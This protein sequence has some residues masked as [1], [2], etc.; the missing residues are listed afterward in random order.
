MNFDL[1]AEQR[2]CRQ[3]ARNLGKKEIAPKVADYN[4]S[5]RFPLEIYKKMGQ[6]GILGGTIPRRWDGAGIDHVSLALV[7]EELGYFCLE[8]AAVVGM[9][10]TMF[11]DI[12]LQHGTERQRERYLRPLCKG[13]TLASCAVTEPQGGSDVAAVA[14]TAVPRGNGYLINGSKSWISYAASADWLLTLARIGD[15]TEGGGFGA[16]IVEKGF[17]GLSISRI[18]NKLGD[19]L[20]DASD[21]FFEDCPVP[22]ENMVGGEGDGLRVILAALEG[23]RLCFAARCCGGI[24]ACL[25]ESTNYA[26][27]RIVFGRPIGQNQLVQ[28]KIADMAVNL[29]CARWLTYHLA[30]LKDT[31]LARATQESSMAKLFAT[32]AFMKA[33]TSAVQIYGAYGC[34]DDSKV[35][36]LFRDAKVHQI[37]EGTSEIH[38]MLIAEYA[39]G[40]RSK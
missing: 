30:W 16:F 33:A 38:I 22:R 21:V 9:I 40:Y 32:D 7:C 29:E 1:T 6:E 2:E 31:G 37:M 28:A 20:G 26:R 15:S 12:L 18:H 36:R 4:R 10:S 5:E 25:D 14:T 8:L 19:R 11:G 17:P 24:K 34:S 27:E 35:A 13:D 3:L 39:L 23:N